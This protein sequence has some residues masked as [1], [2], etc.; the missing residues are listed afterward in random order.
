[1][2]AHSRPAL[3]YVTQEESKSTTPHSPPPYLLQK[4]EEALLLC[5]HGGVECVVGVGPN[6]ASNA[7][8]GNNISRGRH[9]TTSILQTHQT[10]QHSNQQTASQHPASPW[11][12]LGSRCMAC[13][14]GQQGR[15][16]HRSCP[17]RGCSAA[18]YQ[19]DVQ[20]STHS[21]LNYFTDTHSNELL[22]VDCVAHG[23]AVTKLAD[24]C[25]PHRRCC[26]SRC[27]RRRCS[28]A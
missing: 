23:D 13:M 10:N 2:D 18:R 26:S 12:L 22:L 9:A 21:T 6:G 27:R 25:S 4:A 3:G 1:M 14:H 16:K 28:R 20:S 19:Y 11:L 15:K 17:L 24:P 5:W 7:T 8:S